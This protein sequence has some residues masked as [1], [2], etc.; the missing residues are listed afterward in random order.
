MIKLLGL[1]IINYPIKCSKRFFFNLRFSYL[2]LIDECVTRIVFPKTGCD[3][4]FDTYSMDSESNGD[5]GLVLNDHIPSIRS[6][7]FYDLSQTTGSTVN[8]ITATEN[9]IQINLM[10][11][12]VEHLEQTR[13]KLT[14]ALE[15]VLSKVDTETANNL[16]R[17]YSDIF[18]ES[19]STVGSSS[20]IPPPPPPPSFMGNMPPPPPPLPST[21]MPPPPP[22]GNILKIIKE[23]S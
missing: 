10:K 15:N 19:M 13:E 9:E 4:D 21:L 12:R 1:I 5:S 8:N 3:P 16:K 18:G 2:R 6:G 23:N 22:P 17:Q 11:G 14:K 7:S 20:N